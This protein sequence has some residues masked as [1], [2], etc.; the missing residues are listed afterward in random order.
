M[1]ASKRTLSA[2]LTSPSKV[3][4]ALDWRKA[5]GTILSLSV[6]NDRLDMAVGSHP[7]S[8]DD[9][10]PLASIPLKTQIQNGTRALH[11]NVSHELSKIVQDF[12]VC[13]LVVSW[14]VQEE[15]WVG[16]PCGRVLYTLDQLMA[17]SKTLLSNSRPICLWDQ[18]HH[19]PFEDEWGRAAIY[20][21][22]STKSEHYASKEQYQAPETCAADVWDDFCRTHWPELCYLSHSVDEETDSLKPSTSPVKTTWMQSYKDVAAYSRAAQ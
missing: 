1:I 9:V 8:E 5:S 22:A 7:S 16:A 18:A 19:Q 20:A 2:L 11:P 13:G 15:G 14:P 6:Q 21:E 3:A 10:T 17:Q 4:Q 12:E